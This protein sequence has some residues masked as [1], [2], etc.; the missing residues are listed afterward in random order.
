MY[1]VKKK[2]TH[3][4]IYEKLKT[5]KQKGG[6]VKKNPKSKKLTKYHKL[7]NNIVSEVTL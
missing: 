1:K 3:D 2:V 5:H 4:T 7:R 6:W